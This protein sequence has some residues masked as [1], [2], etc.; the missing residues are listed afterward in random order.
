MELPLIQGG[1]AWGWPISVAVALIFFGLSVRGFLKEQLEWSFFAAVFSVGIISSQ[2]F[3]GLNPNMSLEAVNAAAQKAYGIKVVR[4]TS[5]LTNSFLV[6]RDGEVWL[7]ELVPKDGSKPR[8]PATTAPY[9]LF[10]GGKEL[11]ARTP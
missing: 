5:I 2:M 9:G 1:P 8:P 7:C 4:Q 11:P 3:A 6:E 10:C